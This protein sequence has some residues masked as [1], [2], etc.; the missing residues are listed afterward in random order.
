MP[1]SVKTATVWG[2]SLCALLLFCRASYAE[3]PAEP[4]ADTRKVLLR[5]PSVDFHKGSDF[6]FDKFLLA[7]GDQNLYVT[8][9]RYTGPNLVAEIT[10]SF[11][12]KILWTG[13]PHL[14]ARESVAFVTA[15]QKKRQGLV[16]APQCMFFAAST[17][18]AANGKLYGFIVDDVDRGDPD[19]GSMHLVQ[20]LK[21]GKVEWTWANVFPADKVRGTA[22]L[23]CV[24]P[25]EELIMSYGE[26]RLGVFDKDKG[27][28]EIIEIAPAPGR[29]VVP[30]G[31][32]V[33]TVRTRLSAPVNAWDTARL[34]H[35]NDGS[36][37]LMSRR[38]LVWFK[39]DGALVARDTAPGDDAGDVE[40]IGA[41]FSYVV[42]YDSGYRSGLR[43]VEILDSK[44]RV[45]AHTDLLVKKNKCEAMW[46][47]PD[48]VALVGTARDRRSGPITVQYLRVAPLASE[49]AYLEEQERK[50]DA[51]LRRRSDRIFDQMPVVVKSLMVHKAKHGRLPRTL[52][53][54]Q[55]D[56]RIRKSKIDLSKF[57]YVP[58]GMKVAGKNDKG[59]WVVWI[60]FPPS[61]HE[62]DAI[63]VGSTEG[64]T[65]IVRTKDAKVVSKRPIRKN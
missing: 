55:S 65:A 25:K 20:A 21:D 46:M 52:K 24:T 22:T 4:V 10:P 45:V 50:D 16:Q 57:N 2:C 60:A 59:Q 37:V 33:T 7:G 19:Q 31:V 38:E 27:L 56:E 17:L 58:D 3:E 23:L 28:V 1:V 8:G 32:R 48:R 42:R 11:R 6:W 29:L 44:M 5:G 62:P 41:G 14:S 35:M 64:F 13:R 30:K 49:P 15:I 39:R 12:K 47:A 40:Y 63:Y 18:V 26:N 43:K 61:P 36:L 51:I 53:G 9:G 34:F 54:I